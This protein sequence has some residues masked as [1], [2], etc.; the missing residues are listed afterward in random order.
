LGYIKV[1]NDEQGGMHQDL[2]IGEKTT[3][4]I[5][6]LLARESQVVEKDL[7]RFHMI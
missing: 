2:G 6:K 5:G 1:Q 7:T 4:P 3:A